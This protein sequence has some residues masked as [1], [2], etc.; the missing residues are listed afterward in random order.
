M[1]QRRYSWMRNSPYDRKASPTNI[2]RSAAMRIVLAEDDDDMRSILSSALRR[3]GYEVIEA[4]DGRE[5]LSRLQDDE[6]ATTRPNLVISDVRM[7]G[8]SGMQVLATLRAS[9]FATPVILIT[10]F[11]DEELHSEAAEHGATAVFDKPFDVDRLR[12]TVATLV[13]AAP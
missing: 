1:I 9:D 7:P 11:G 4:A 12:E 10:G 6:A 2:E 8:L 5:L 3:D 13:P